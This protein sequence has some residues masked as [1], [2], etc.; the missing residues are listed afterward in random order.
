MTNFE[1]ELVRK[2][3][4]AGR[5][6]LLA[7]VE[8]LSDAQAAFKPSSQTWSVLECIEHVVV[9]GRQMLRMIERAAIV[10]GW[11]PAA[12][13]QDRIFVSRAVDRAR[14]FPAPDSASPKSRFATLDDARREFLEARKRTLAFIEQSPEDLR[15]RRLVHPVAGPIDAYHCLLLIAAHPSRHAAQILEIRSGA[16]FPASQP[17][18]RN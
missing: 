6:T 3:L 18:W 10:E 12:L 15:A 9:S 8:R 16:G 13:G 7:A 14:R 17:T 1:L 5:Q 2:Q 11:Q 4:S